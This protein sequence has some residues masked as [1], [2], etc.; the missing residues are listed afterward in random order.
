M[1]LLSTKGPFAGTPCGGAAPCPIP[2]EQTGYCFGSIPGNK[3]GGCG[4]SE[5]RIGRGGGEEPIANVR[6]FEIALGTAPR[7][8]C[9]KMKMKKT[10][11][12]SPAGPSLVDHSLVPRCKECN[13]PP[14]GSCEGRRGWD[15]VGF[16]GGAGM[17]CELSGGR[18]ALSFVETRERG[19]DSALRVPPE[20]PSC[21]QIKVGNGHR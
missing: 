11:S 13:L 9:Q 19:K 17:S 5:S 3:R 6:R 2:P 10:R 1:L 12:N 20:G 14:R 18:E 16:R 21:V 8:V 7:F 15:C 4:V